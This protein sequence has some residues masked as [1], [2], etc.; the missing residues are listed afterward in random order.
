MDQ[1]REKR[2][3]L[4]AGL[5]A[6]QSLAVA[7]SGGVDSSF[8]AAVTREVLGDRMLALTA[9][10]PVHPR[11]EHQAALKFA[12]AFAIPLIVIATDE[13]AV[14]GFA[15]NPPDR[16]YL[17]K[18]YLMS[19]MVA[20]ARERG[21]NHVAHGANLDDLGDYRPGAK[22]A[23]ELGIAAPLIDAGLTK[24]E[25]RNLSR[26][27]G[28]PTWNRPSMACLA[29]RIPY[30]NP[31]S[32]RVLERVA[33]AEDT[34]HEMGF[35]ACRVRHHGNIARI[36]VDPGEFSYLVEKGMRASLVVKLKALGYDHICLDLEGYVQGS[37]NRALGNPDQ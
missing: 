7:F 20:Q 23:R 22:A 14:P 27:M 2:D 34:L 1:L 25:I 21:F 24:A 36:E 13:M 19:Q 10:S 9:V 17:C 4:T 28:L 15:D 37:L 6:Y 35:K 3:K 8:L 5:K 31:I 12:A 29:S 18:K 32:L 16:C 26:E 30:G 11:R 33:E